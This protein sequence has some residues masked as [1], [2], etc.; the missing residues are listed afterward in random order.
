M[1]C[2]QSKVS[3]KSSSI[4]FGSFSPVFV[5]QNTLYQQLD[6]IK[7]QANI[8]DKKKFK[9]EIVNHIFSNYG[10]IGFEEIQ[11]FLNGVRK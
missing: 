8:T 7:N 5:D 2:Y 4:T 10:K 9:E 3:G 11:N 6:V 1:I